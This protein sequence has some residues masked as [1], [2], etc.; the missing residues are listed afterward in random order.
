MKKKLGKLKKKNSVKGRNEAICLGAT[1]DQWEKATD[2][3]ARQRWTPQTAVLRS[4]ALWN[5]RPIQLKECHRKRNSVKK[6]RKIK[7]KKKKQRQSST[8]TVYQRPRSS[9]VVFFFKTKST[10]HSIPLGRSRPLIYIYKKKKPWTLNSIF[11][12]IHSFF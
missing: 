9:S 2:K 6:K 12:M 10:F 7:C 5:T 1:S 8:L 11:E 3:A 4:L